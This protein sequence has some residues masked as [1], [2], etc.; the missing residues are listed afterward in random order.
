MLTS[1]KFLTLAFLAGVD[2]LAVLAIALVPL[3]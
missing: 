3:A 2:P 1:G